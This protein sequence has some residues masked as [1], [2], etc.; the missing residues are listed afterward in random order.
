MLELWNWFFIPIFKFYSPCVEHCM[1]LDLHTTY[2]IA[3]NFVGANFRMVGQSALRIN[4]RLQCSGRLCTC[5]AERLHGHVQL[6]SMCT[7]YL[8]DWND[9]ERLPCLQEYLGCYHWRRVRSLGEEF[10]ALAKNRYR[11]I[12]SICSSASDCVW[13]RSKIAIGGL[14]STSENKRLADFNLA[15]NWVRSSHAQKLVP[16]RAHLR[17][18]RIATQVLLPSTEQAA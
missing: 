11:D 18:Y 15:D 8:L 6:L 12:V 4:F 10:E 1:D 13:H 17:W 9:G 7:Q 16:V 5:T 14:A 3:E 2:R